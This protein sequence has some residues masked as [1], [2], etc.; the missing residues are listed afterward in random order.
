MLSSPNVII[1]DLPDSRL[2][3]VE[4]GSGD[5]ALACNWS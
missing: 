4:V 2:D 3:V 5:W 1:T